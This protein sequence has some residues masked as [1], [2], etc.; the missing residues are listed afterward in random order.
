MSNFIS[1]IKKHKKLAVI[2][3]AVL[4]AAVAAAVLASVLAKQKKDR[5]RKAING[6]FIL[7]TRI[8]PFM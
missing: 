6:R 2:C 4:A 1:N 5:S 7:R 8:I 3:A